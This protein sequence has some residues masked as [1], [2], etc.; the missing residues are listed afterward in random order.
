MKNSQSKIAIVIGLVISVVG[1]VVVANASAEQSSDEP[2]ITTALLAQEVDDSVREAFKVG[3]LPKL[4]VAGPGEGVTISNRTIATA[5]LVQD[6]DGSV[7]EVL[8]V[9]ESPKLEVAGP[10]DEVT[11][12]GRNGGDVTM[13]YSEF[14]AEVRRISDEYRADGGAGEVMVGV[15]D[16]GKIGIIG[17]CEP[18][19]DRWLYEPVVDLFERNR[20]GFNADEFPRFNCGAVPGATWVAGNG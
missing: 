12:S 1:L 3:E 19:D 8:K 10:D 14:R 17:V 7:R 5:P 18:V 20:A 16:D 2:E 13:N 9:G 11:I 15:R 4:E 6:L